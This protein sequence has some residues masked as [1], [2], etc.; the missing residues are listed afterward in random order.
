MLETK[1]FPIASIKIS[2]TR[3]GRMKGRENVTDLIESIGRVGLLHPL[4]FGPENQLVAG[5]RRLA[6]V[7][8]LGWQTVPVVVAKTLDDAVKLLEAERDENTCRLALAPSMFVEIGRTIVNLK[9]PEA[10]ERQ[11]E[12]GKAGGKLAGK[13]RPKDDRVTESYGKANRHD[14]E[15]AAKAAKAVGVSARTYEKAEAVV[16]AAEKEPAKYGKLVEEMDRTGKVDGAFKNLKA[17][18]KQAEQEALPDDLPDITDRYRLFHARIEKVVEQIPDESIDVIVTDPPYPKEFLPTYDALGALAARV[19]K[20]GGSLVAMCGHSYLPTILQM[21]GGHLAYQ[22]TLAY[23]TPG[24][25]AA[26]MWDRRVNTFWKPLVWMVK[27]KYAGDWIGDVCQSQP[28][29]NDKRFHHWGQSES[30]MADIVRRFTV[31]GQTILD[32]F[33]GGGTTGVVAIQMNRKFIGIDC[34][35]VALEKTKERLFRCSDES[36]RP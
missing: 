30:G 16:A 12:G 25:Q 20:P 36:E 18:Q 19:L 13:G 2:P 5:A 15:T 4:V 23:L 21:L 6:A 34:D 28:N 17:A 10:K 11:K 35:S 26:Q 32:P 14:Q 3:C 33:C 8:Q 1:S 22:W 27:D 29:G 7:K 31:P 24:G 9:G